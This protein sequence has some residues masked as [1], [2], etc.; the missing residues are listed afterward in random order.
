MG[1]LR[2]RG[3]LLERFEHFTMP[4]PNTGCWLWNGE[5]T[6]WGY[7]HL[8]YAG[9]KLRAHR[10]SYEL[11]KGP[12]PVGLEIDHLCRVR[13][14]VN[15]DHLEA[16]TRSANMRRSP[17]IMRRGRT[18]CKNGHPYDG[19]HS[20]GYRICRTCNRQAYRRYDAKRRA[21]LGAGAP[22]KPAGAV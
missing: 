13:C 2:Q 7:G 19:W 4:E 20:D 12:I 8:S 3:P 9:R 1:L 11:F 16:V 14:C 10:V 17:L 5:I 15:P 22:V 18:H 6:L 21:P